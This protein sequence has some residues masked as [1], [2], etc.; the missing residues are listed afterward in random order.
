MDRRYI[1]EHHVVAR[2][3]ADRVTDAERSGF[4]A[5]LLEHADMV[6]EMEAAARFKVGLMQ[7]QESGE[8]AKLM[9]P[10]PRYLQWKFI[11]AAAAVVLMLMLGVYEYS[12]RATSLQLIATNIDTLGA[13]GELPEIAA[14]HAIFRTRAGPVD[15]EIVQT[16]AGQVVELRV[17]PEFTADPARYRIVLARM[18]MDDSVEAVADLGGLVP[19][20][21]RFVNVFLAAAR[22]KPGQYQL[23]ISGDLGTDAEDKESAFVVVVKSGAE[24]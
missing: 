15:A 4:E 10:K 5:Y 22:L 12:R 17:L 11:A 21:D 13:G 8:L 23:T 3:L 1:D 16:K 20:S 7:L 14:K 18:S 2:Y 19:A 9:K 24:H 6:Q